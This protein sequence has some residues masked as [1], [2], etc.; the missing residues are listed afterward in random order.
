MDP[1]KKNTEKKYIQCSLRLPLGVGITS[2]LLSPVSQG[3]F[4]ACHTVIS[5]SEG[6]FSLFHKLLLPQYARILASPRE[7][8]TTLRSG[9]LRTSVLCPSSEIILGHILGSASRVSQ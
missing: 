5:M 2:A 3:G 4:S 6:L 7:Q 1:L 9:C 8:S